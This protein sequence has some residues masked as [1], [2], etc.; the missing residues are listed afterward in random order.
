MLYSSK[1]NKAQSNLVG[2]LLLILV[3]GASPR[4]GCMVF[5]PGGSSPTS[6]DFYTSLAV[7]MINDQHLL[8]NLMINNYFT[9]ALILHEESRFN[10]ALYHSAPPQ[11]I[12]IMDY[13][14]HLGTGWS[15]L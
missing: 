5:F 13:R 11:M 7:S 9:R 3:M 1:D 15:A 2:Q 6:E 4:L 10:S 12:K 8:I 14:D